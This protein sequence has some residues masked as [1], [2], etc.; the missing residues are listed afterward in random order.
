[1]REAKSRRD[2]S[3]SAVCEALSAGKPPPAGLALPVSKRNP[4]A[5]LRSVSRARLPQ[6]LNRAAHGTLRSPA[7]LF[8]STCETRRIGSTNIAERMLGAVEFPAAGLRK[9]GLPG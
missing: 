9:L 5:A 4:L 7:L 6:L 1:M 3:W 8:T 2:R